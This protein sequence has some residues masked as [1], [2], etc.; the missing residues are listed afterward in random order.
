MSS[1]LGVVDLGSNSFRMFVARVQADRAGAYRIE[2]LDE[3]KDTVRLAAGLTAE[4]RLEPAAQ[5]R[6]I[7]ALA[8]FRERLGGCAPR[9]VRAVATNT[10]RVALNAHE[11]LGRAQVALGHP[12]EVIS[13]RQEASLIYRGAI[14]A[15]AGPAERRLVMDIGGG[16]TELIVGRGERIDLLDSIALGCVTLTQRHFA[17]G[18]IDRERWDRALDDAYRRVLPAA[19]ALRWQEWDSAWGTSGTFKALVRIARAELGHEALTRTGARRLRDRLIEAGHVGRIELGGLKDERRPVLPGGFI[20]AQAL[21]DLL[22]IDALRYAPGAL[23]E[24]VLLEMAEAA[25]R[26]ERLQAVAAG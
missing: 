4:S 23:R 17:D 12:I 26:R 24:G 21:F 16:S 22:P 5:A 1:L 18:R 10:L 2:V 6:G 20:A 8:R 7:A 19:R 9:S 13:G 3:A 14:H 25:A 11:F 15:L